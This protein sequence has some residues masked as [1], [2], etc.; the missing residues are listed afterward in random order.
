[1][2]PVRILI[3]EDELIVARDIAR[4]LT[5]LGYEPVGETS[6]GDDAM[7][8]AG[9]LRPDLVLMDIQL[10]G[11]L[12]GIDAAREI[13]RQFS[14]PVIFL[15]A[16]ASA[17][18]VARATTAGPFG[19]IVK[20]FDSGELRMVIE[21]GLNQH[22]T[23]LRL[24]RSEERMQAMLRAS[25][26][27]FWVID[28]TG[29]VGEVNDAACQVMGYS[30]PE[31]LGMNIAQLEHD[32]TPAQIAAGIA[33]VIQAGSARMER[34][35][36]RRDGQVRTIEMSVTCPPGP[37]RLLYCFSRDI[38]ERRQAEARLQ[39]L[40]RAVE[41][42]PASIVITDT[43]GRIEY[44]NPHFEKVT[45][46]TAEEAVGQNPRVLKS[47]AQPP[48]F[49]RQLWQALATG[50]AWSG[51]FH[52]RR[53]DGT[54]FWEKA[55][56]SPMRDPDGRMTHYIAVKEDIT[57]QKQAALDLARRESCLTAIIENHRGLVWLKDRE[58]R[59]LA[60]NRAFAHACGVD[61]PALIV[62]R[63]DFDCWP[64]SSAEASYVDDRRVIEHGHSVT[65]EEQ[66][67]LE[68]QA[69]WVET[70]KTPVMDAAG[71]VIGTAGNAV[72]IT[73]RR[74][75]QQEL[76][77]AKE[78][79][80]TSS[81]AKSAFLAAMSHELRTPLNVIN[82]VAATLLDQ[83]LTAPHR[84]ALELSLQS[85]HGL[86]AI[87]EEILDFSSLQAGKIQIDSAP[88]DLAPL[89]HQVMRQAAGLPAAK[90]LTL[91]ASCDPALP[92]RI[93][94]DA[95]RFRQVL[96]NLLSN[97]VK[98]TAH[99]AVHLVVRPRCGTADRPWLHCSVVDTGIGIDA[100]HRELIFEPFAQADGSIT[101]RF[102][103]TGLGLAISRS[104]VQL[105]GGELQL[106]SHPGVGSAFHFSIPYDPAPAAPPSP[107][108]P[109]GTG[110][111]GEKLLMA[112]TVGKRRRMIAAY[113]RALGMDVTL[114]DPARTTAL[115]LSSTAPTDIALIESAAVTPASPLRS[116]LDSRC[117]SR[118]LPVLWLHPT[119][120]AVPDG[121]GASVGT[122]ACA[123]DPAVLALELTKLLKR[124]RASIPPV[125]A[126]TRQ[127]MVGPLGERIPLSILA[128][129]DIHT[130]RLVIKMIL[131]QLGYDCTLVNNG[132]E[133][134][135]AIRVQRYDLVLLDVQMPVMDGLTAARA[136]C[137]QY[138]DAKSRP[139]VVALT[140]NALPGD[141]EN[142]LAA[143]MDDYLSKPINAA[144]LVTC[145]ERLFP[146]EADPVTAP[147]PLAW[148]DT[149]HLQA[150][151]QDLTATQVAET[152]HQLNAAAAADFATV[153][154]QVRVAC[155]DHNSEALR[156]AIHGLKGCFQMLGWPQA[157]QCCVQALAEV[158]AGHFSRWTTLPHEL[159]TLCQTS[160]G[161]MNRYLATHPD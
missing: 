160:Q 152:L 147:P 145:I 137:R 91:T 51:E 103:G 36:L 104:F 132:E 71:T 53:K 23:E 87:I 135:A 126:S 146:P 76:I 77:R 128:V 44:V 65:V 113:T 148:I 80:E 70:Y 138:P 56:I 149:G 69:V 66:I 40:T 139:K 63:T 108:G 33:A 74:R 136:I 32:R 64:R 52:N 8:L 45:G 62:G 5:A 129:D 10:S 27:S 101:R 31:L 130:N 99:G 22:R 96:L 90:H 3:V 142:C 67:F 114:I 161:A 144:S 30:R 7:Q 125:T 35:M 110:L 55:S 115:A 61:D 72:D 119:S 24:Q 106:R 73:E 42:S 79:A 111:K 16:Y 19:Y 6:R 127:T 21:V 68:G 78:A 112:V 54:L 29:R 157:S 150:I 41:Q 82:G 94:G 153:L 122:L 57:A 46:Y 155:A 15:T 159:H 98:F 133:A 2:S 100:A 121:A 158:R 102:G 18:M 116:W 59:F 34:Q 95:R 156:T 9:R 20:P 25:M 105:M 88:F 140:A 117:H 85:G 143:G 37:D 151:T 81:R 123:V 107:I 124:T 89:L 75:A 47:G 154:P 97:A 26:D 50:Q 13:R 141:R 49:Y 39:Q 60:V 93:T 28:P 92:S 48:E 83:T 14:L 86:L 1:M 43:T 17:P 84:E 12:D 38:T 58:G 131:R 120:L 134:L 118:P 109:A 4:Q 11:P